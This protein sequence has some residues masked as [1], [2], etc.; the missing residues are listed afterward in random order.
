VTPDVRHR[1]LVVDDHVPTAV[2]FA[3]LIQVLGHEVRITHDGTTTLSCLDTYC[4]DIILLDIGLPGL[5]GY[6]VARRLRATERG[7]H[8][9]L[10]ALSGYGD[11]EDFAR[12]RG[13]GF[14]QYLLKPVSFSALASVLEAPTT[15]TP[16]DEH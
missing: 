15:A 5:N 16:L 9:K 13:V 3:R 6:E 1:I 11:V 2:A 8:V 4:P 7:G 12:A 10:V 14:D